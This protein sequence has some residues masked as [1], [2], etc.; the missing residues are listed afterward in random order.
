MAPV[1]SLPLIAIGREFANA[2]IPGA[3]V[4]GLD[5][6]GVEDGRADHLPDPAPV[7]ERILGHRAGG[8]TATG[9]ESQEQ[10]TSE[11]SPHTVAGEWANAC[12]MA[13]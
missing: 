7:R 9:N 4:L 12:G 5:G 11:E 13:K 10:K 3:A 2:R 6:R 1:K 8:T